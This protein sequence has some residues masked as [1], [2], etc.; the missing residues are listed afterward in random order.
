VEDADLLLSTIAKAAN[1]AM[2]PVRV[3]AFFKRTPE[4]LKLDWETFVQTKYG[5]FQHFVELPEPVHTGVF[6]DFIVVDVP[7]S[8]CS[9]RGVRTYRIADPAHTSD[10]TRVNVRVDSEIGRALSIINWR[11]PESKSP[12]V[13]NATLE[14]TWSNDETPVLEISRFICWEFLGLG[15]DA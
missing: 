7:E 6:R 9:Q 11:G 10:S 3:H 8:G 12:Q 2:E 1:F 4:G 14:L 15:G 13:R 5:T